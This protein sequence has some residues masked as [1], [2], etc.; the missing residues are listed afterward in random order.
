MSD[1]D[2]VS[3][4]SACRLAPT[5]FDHRGHLRIA[6]LLVH[7]HP[8]ECAIEETCAGIARIARLFGAPDKFN[9]TLSEALVR[10]IADAANRA[11]AATFEEFLLGNSAFVHDVR[12]VLAHYYSPSLLHSANAKR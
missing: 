11:P 8:L 2:F 4:F 12:G 10:L 6:W 1:D 5:D 3:A 9:R 7:R